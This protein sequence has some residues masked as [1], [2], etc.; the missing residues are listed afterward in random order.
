MGEYWNLSSKR[1]VQKNL[2]RCIRDVIGSPDDVGD[3]HLDIVDDD[4]DMVGR[5]GV[6]AQQHKVLD[7]VAFND[8]F[9]EGGNDE[10]DSTIRYLEAHRAQQASRKPSLNFIRAMM[11]A[12][13]VILEIKLACGLVACVSV[14]AIP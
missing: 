11:Q 14:R 9:A 7:R 5:L 10:S 6:R 1:T 13:A 4:A 2:L 8:D 12:G 3:P